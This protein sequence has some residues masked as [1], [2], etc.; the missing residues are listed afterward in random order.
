MTIET[1]SYRTDIEG[2]SEACQ[3]AEREGHKA[4]LPRFHFFYRR[5]EAEQD[6]AFWFL[7]GAR[8]ALDKV[9]AS[10]H[11]SG[12]ASRDS[13]NNNRQRAS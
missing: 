10:G 1:E 9:S 6:A 7:Q 5:R 11:T 8:S 3:R 12:T 2:F 4:F 13:G